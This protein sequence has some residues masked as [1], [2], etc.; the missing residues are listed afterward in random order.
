MGYHN[1]AAAS[2]AAWEGGW[3]HTGDVVREG[4]EGSLHF[5][6]R[7]KNVIRRSSEN[8]AALEVESVILELE[9]VVAAT[10]I[11]AP[12][13]LRGEE[14]MAFVVV[15][16]GVPRDATA[17]A[18]VSAWC[19]QQLAYYKAP[20][21]VAFRDALPLTATQKVRKAELRPLTDDLAALADCFDMRNRK[22]AGRVP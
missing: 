7:R 17:A 21:W 8:I 2:E 9:W 10:V 12:D 15:G 13:E 11:A 4:P 19:L 6:D 16:A 20:G 1:D 22:R 5:V 3:F 14:V 18:K